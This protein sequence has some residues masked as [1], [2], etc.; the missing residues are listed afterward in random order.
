MTIEH[1]PLFPG[2]TANDL[3]VA[4]K[5][6]REAAKVGET[7]ER[8]E[9]GKNATWLLDDLLEGVRG[10]PVSLIATTWTE[11]AAILEA[12]IDRLDP[13]PP[14]T[15]LLT[16]SPECYDGFGSRTLDP[17]VGCDDRGRTIRRVSV[18]NLHFTWQVT[19]YDSGCHAW[20]T[21]EDAA[22]FSAIW[23]LK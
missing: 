12:E 23:R 20:T 14:S 18:A 5:A 2:A 6:C 10:R 11:K 3:R 8:S 21:P 17:D 4:A 22:R 1:K 7:I 9:Q 19:R 13:P 16:V 15:I